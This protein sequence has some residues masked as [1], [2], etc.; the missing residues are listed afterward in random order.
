[1]AD[2][3][4]TDE[5]QETPIVSS[6]KASEDQI[7]DAEVIE[8]VPADHAA[9]STDQDV[10]PDTDEAIALQEP[11]T[12]APADE[13]EVSDE[14]APEETP[15]DDADEVE[16]TAES[17][18]ETVEDD[19]PVVDETPAPAPV[20][21]PEADPAPRKGGFL[22]M[23]LG[24]VAAGVI[25]F[26]VGQYSNDGWPFNGAAEQS[27]FEADTQA[28]LADLAKADDAISGRVDATEAALNDIDLSALDQLAPIAGKTEDLAAASQSQADQLQALADQL[29][30]L[31]ARFD[32]LEKRPV[33]ETVSPEAIAAYERELENLR[34]AM[35]G[36]RAEI[37]TMARD[38]VAAEQ[39]AEAQAQIA[40]ARAALAEVVAGLDTGAGFA[41]SLQTIATSAGATVP[42]ALAAV[43]ADGAP[44][45]GALI[46]AF[47]EAARAALSA[48]RATESGE[49]SGRI[50]TFLLDRV[51]A[52]SVAPREGT[53]A[54]AV[55]SRAEAA[56]KAGD[57]AGALAELS[58]LPEVAQAEMNAWAA[59]AQTRLDALQAAD[60]LS[61][62]LNQK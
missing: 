3:K 18:A 29:A 47:P 43:A 32:E 11:G 16:L 19:A 52:R 39:N 15:A 13:T 10:E 5:P 50:A 9:E 14:P 60:A 12:E 49:G 21:P 23:L 26:G 17:D 35:E 30:A 48:A 41:D 38:A 8:E 7:A 42:D 37:E 22:P 1:M 56:V 61:Q 33:A 59:L 6:E 27:T 46:E 25:G 44:T 45:Q 53:D 57:I 40:R 36:Q 24:G 2:T 62:E 31:T 4:N 20:A 54:D 28:A 55:L 51:G 58:A 34:L